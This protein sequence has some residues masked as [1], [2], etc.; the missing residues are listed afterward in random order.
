MTAQVCGAGATPAWS[1]IGSATLHK[2]V[3]V[4]VGTAPMSR[5]NAKASPSPGTPSAPTICEF[6][7]GA[8]RHRRA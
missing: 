4:I 8:G 1:G 6:S 2:V 7:R 3:D 5:P